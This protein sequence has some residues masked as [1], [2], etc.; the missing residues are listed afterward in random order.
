MQC[1]LG[2]NSP[3]LK[4][5]KLVHISIGVIDRSLRKNQLLRNSI[6]LSLFKILNNKFIASL[7]KI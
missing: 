6:I 3:L 1:H 5:T 2:S 4:N 7:F